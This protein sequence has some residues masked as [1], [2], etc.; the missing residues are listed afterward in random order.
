M[1]RSDI[2]HFQMETSKSGCVNHRAPFPAW[3]ALKSRVEITASQNE[4]AAISLGSWETTINTALSSQSSSDIEN[5]RKTD[6][7]YLKPLRFGDCLHNLAFP[8]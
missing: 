1:S 5:E 3:L 7:C 4:G 2:C 6:L 8:D